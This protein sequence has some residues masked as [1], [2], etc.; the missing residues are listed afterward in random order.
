[1]RSPNPTSRGQIQP[2]AAIALG[3]IAAVG[4]AAAV[5]ASRPAAPSTPGAS[6]G[7]PA[8]SVAPS[9][10]PSATPSIAP[11]VTPAAPPS[12]APSKA[13]LAVGLDN[14]T[15]HAV[16][17]VIHD[18]T[19]TV[20]AAVSGKPGDGMSVRWHD[21][22]VKNRG[23]RS[24]AITWAGLPGDD[25]VD[26]GVRFDKD[27]YSLT[28]VQAGPVPNSD[29]MGEDRVL[30]LTFDAPVAAEDVSIEVLDRT[31]D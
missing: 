12:A 3:L 15:G 21:A 24:I 28:M 11:S 16:S 1:M 20:S 8:P 13:P 4:L 7:S 30:V 29:A 17:I 18:E 6:D 26:L 5:L 27:R 10:A 22:V 9:A 31:V 2:V 19:G 25:L 23:D 14:S